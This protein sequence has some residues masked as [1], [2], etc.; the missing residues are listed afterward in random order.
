LP[1]LGPLM[2]VEVTK[3]N[4]LDL[5]DSIAARGATR[6]ADTAR[7]MVSSIYSFGIDR[8]LIK[9][10]PASG[11]RSRHEDL[12]RDVVL[13]P[14]QL[15]R[16]WQSLASGEAV[17][18]PAMAR[19]I[20]LALLTGQR[21]AEITSTR[22]SDLDLD[23]SDPTLVIGRSRAKNHNTHRVPLSLQAVVEFR[24]AIASADSDGTWTG[25]PEEGG[26][27]SWERGQAVT[28]TG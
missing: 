10:N 3:Q 19:I 20:R 15:R 12:P 22:V 7:A 8:G 4:V 18:T 14:D 16:L 26:Q 24:A 21:R 23:G 28:L 5:I 2:A 11:L 1:A 13:T 17:A 27:D 6:R 9:D 25:I